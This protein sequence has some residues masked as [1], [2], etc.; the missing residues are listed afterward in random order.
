VFVAKV[1]GFAGFGMQYVCEV[2]EH[3][4]FLQQLG[5]RHTG[6]AA[7]LR[8]QFLQYP[9]VFAQYV[10]YVPHIIIGIAVQRIVVRI[11]ALV[12]TKLFIGSSFYGGTATQAGFCFGHKQSFTARY[13]TIYKRLQTVTS[14][15]KRLKYGSCFCPA[16]P[17]PHYSLTAF[18]FTDKRTEV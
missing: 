4:P 13:K 8:I 5:L 2:I 14:D 11:A 15:K 16:T 10:V 7:R 12:V 18:V 6:Y 1:V 17:L 9:P 3:K